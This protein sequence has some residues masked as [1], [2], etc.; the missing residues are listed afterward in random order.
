MKNFLSILA[1]S[2]EGARN[3]QKTINEIHDLLE[4]FSNAIKAGTGDKV[5]VVRVEAIEGMTDGFL[6]NLAL[7]L[8]D[9]KRQQVLALRHVDAPD[10]RDVQL[11]TWREDALGYPCTVGFRDR[12]YIC[13]NKLALSTALE[14]IIADSSVALAI[15][16]L[17]TAK[18]KVTNA[19]NIGRDSESQ[20]SGVDVSV[21]K[22]VNEKT[23]QEK[24]IRGRDAEAV[25]ENMRAMRVKQISVRA[26]K[27]PAAVNV[28]P[29]PIVAKKVANTS[30]DADVV[31]GPKKIRTKSVLSGEKKSRASSSAKTLGKKSMG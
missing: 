14:E 25:L 5:Y 13:E 9:P 12:E 29:T 19:R 3:A 15:E 16:K 4:D 8:K 22:V 31:A 6:R 10:V 2:L 23:R 7:F 17:R 21:E 28:K 1:T 20:T 30:R 24:E 26:I 27:K 18:L 11:A